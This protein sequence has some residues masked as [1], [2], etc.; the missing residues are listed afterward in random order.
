[1]SAGRDAVLSAIRTALGRGALEGEALAAAEARIAERSRNLIPQRGQRPPAERVA[2][3]V[4][5]AEAVSATV[6]RVDGLDA[7]P[8]AVASFLAGLNLPSAIRLA[9]DPAL[10]AIPWDARPTLEVTSGRAEDRD[11]TSVTAA[12]AGIAETGT[13][14]LASSAASPTT[15]NFLPDNHIVVLHAGQV[16]GAYEDGWDL[17]RANGGIPRTVNFVTGPSR[18]GDIEQ[19]IQLGAHGPRRLHIVLVEDGG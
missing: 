7:V 17:L 18:T 2:L 6:V 14:M 16:V 15:L 1:M 4:E 13:L 10:A 3:F 8:D 9:P 19:K 12:A 5:M 11:L